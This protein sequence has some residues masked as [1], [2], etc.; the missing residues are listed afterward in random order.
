MLIILPVPRFPRCLLLHSRYLSCGWHL[1]YRLTTTQTL[2]NPNLSVHLDAFLSFSE[3]LT[4]R[5][6][7]VLST[8]YQS[9]TR[10]SQLYHPCLQPLPSLMGFPPSSQLDLTTTDN[11]YSSAP[12]RLFPLCSQYSQYLIS[13]FHN[14]TGILSAPEFWVHISIL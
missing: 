10:L 9:W 7:H 1:L 11:N 5:Q 3:N 14:F 13:N 2:T 4:V 6:L 8:W 12:L